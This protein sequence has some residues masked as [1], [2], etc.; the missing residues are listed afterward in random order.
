MSRPGLDGP[1][2]PTHAAMQHEPAQMSGTHIN[3]LH[4]TRSAQG[5]QYRGVRAAG[6]CG[7]L[8]WWCPPWGMLGPFSASSGKA[9]CPG[10]DSVGDD[11]Q[12]TWPVLHDVRR[13][14]GRPS[15]PTRAVAQ[16]TCCCCSRCYILAKPAAS[17]WA[18]WCQSLPC[19]YR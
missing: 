19:T 8:T 17:Q 16:P 13:C 18:S 12:L 7:E 1:G 11:I 4:M 14:L 6:R 10:S 2:T 3:G 5:A 15:S 9:M